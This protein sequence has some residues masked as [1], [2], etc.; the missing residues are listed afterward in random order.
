MRNYYNK[1]GIVLVNREERKHL[2]IGFVYIE[3]YEF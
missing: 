1:Q 3:F 2:S